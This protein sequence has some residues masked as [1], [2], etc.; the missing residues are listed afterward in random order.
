MDVMLAVALVKNVFRLSVAPLF[1]IYLLRYKT[2]AMNGKYCF[3]VS[4]LEPA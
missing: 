3:S 1:V 4:S 2:I